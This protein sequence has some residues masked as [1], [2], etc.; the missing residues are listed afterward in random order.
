MTLSSGS[1]V[2]ECICRVPPPPRPAPQVAV[3][4]HSTQHWTIAIQHSNAPQC[5]AFAYPLWPPAPPA[6]TAQPQSGPPS[7][8]LALFTPSWASGT[9]VIKC[10]KRFRLV[11]AE[12]ELPCSP[13]SDP[14][15]ALDSGTAMIKW[16]SFFVLAAQCS[17]G[18]RQ[19]APAGAQPAQCTAKVTTSS[20]TGTVQL[21]W[22]ISSCVW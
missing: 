9:A 1:G 17:S 12:L 21:T 22:A 13:A 2:P 16:R 11:C 4:Q 6:P 14:P 10:Q 8:S 7:S 18:G 20:T 19:H 5:A 3:R 15:S